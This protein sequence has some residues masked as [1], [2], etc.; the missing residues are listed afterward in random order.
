MQTT[1]YINEPIIIK[2]AMHPNRRETNLGNK[3]WKY[4][5]R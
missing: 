5:K 4:V 2:L 3:P 1:S